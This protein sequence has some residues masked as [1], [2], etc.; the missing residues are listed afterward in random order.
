MKQLVFELC[1]LNDAYVSFKCKPISFR[2]VLAETA[3]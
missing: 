3:Q 1:P 2:S